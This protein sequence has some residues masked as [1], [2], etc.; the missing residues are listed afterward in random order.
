M[1]IYEDANHQWWRSATV[2]DAGMEYCV[3]SMGSKY[4]GTIAEF[5]SSKEPHS[6]I[7]RV[8]MI[9]QKKRQWSLDIV[10]VKCNNPKE[11]D[12][13]TSNEMTFISNL[14]LLDEK[15]ATFFHEEHLDSP[16]ISITKDTW[17]SLGHPSKITIKLEEYRPTFLTVEDL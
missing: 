7:E 4:R 17:N 5:I 12:L 10:F 13:S 3:E 1:S 2:D 11:K 6:D 16:K 9:D 15:E 8:S 14:Q